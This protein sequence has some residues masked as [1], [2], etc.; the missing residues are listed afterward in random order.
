M[1]TGAVLKK[2]EKRN[3]KSKSAVFRRKRQYQTHYSR[4]AATQTWN[5]SLASIPALLENQFIFGIEGGGGVDVS[6]INGLFFVIVENR[7]IVHFLD[8]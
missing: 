7:Y 2:R 5:W 3:R 4:E 1:Q 6:F 8:P